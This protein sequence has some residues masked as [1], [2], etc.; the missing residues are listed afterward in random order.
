MPAGQLVLVFPAAY[1]GRFSVVPYVKKI[2]EYAHLENR[3]MWEYALDLDR[4]ELGWAG[5]GGQ[6]PLGIARYQFRLLFP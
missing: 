2:R 4:D 6:S 5:L 3:D 1:P